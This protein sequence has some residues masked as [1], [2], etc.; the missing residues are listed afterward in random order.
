MLFILV[1]TA[2][3]KRPFADKGAAGRGG[4]AAGKTAACG[5]PSVSGPRKGHTRG[6][7]LLW[8]NLTDNRKKCR[9]KKEKNI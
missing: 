3:D 2:I 4:G 9:K 5:G 7:N 6:M 1:L 8:V